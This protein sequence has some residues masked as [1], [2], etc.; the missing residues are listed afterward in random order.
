MACV[1]FALECGG[2]FLD[3]DEVVLDE[4]MAGEDLEVFRLSDRRD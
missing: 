2:M 3:R 4:V 1:V